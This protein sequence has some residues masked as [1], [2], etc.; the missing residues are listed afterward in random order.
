METTAAAIT[1]RAGSSGVPSA[2]KT[3]GVPVWLGPQADGSNNL[4]QQRRED[5]A[6]LALFA[7]YV[8]S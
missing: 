4:D 6:M 3:L 8:R 2:N 5:L 7:Q 1:K